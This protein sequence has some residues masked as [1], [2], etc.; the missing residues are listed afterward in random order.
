MGHTF[1]SKTDYISIATGNYLG[2]GQCFTLIDTPGARDTLGK[3]IF[4]SF[5]TTL[6]INLILINFNSFFH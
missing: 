1:E 3:N 2:T 4:M 5:Q 6:N